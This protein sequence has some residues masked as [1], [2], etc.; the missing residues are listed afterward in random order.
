MAAGFNPQMLLQMLSRGRGGA[1]GGEES[2][3]PASREL[4]GA[5]PEYALKLVNDLKKKAADLIPMLAFR[6]PAAARA[7]ASTFKGL[8]A[9]IKELQQAQATL[10]AVGGPINMAAVPKPQPPGSTGAPGLSMAA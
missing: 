6:A 8:D 3:A 7:L 2:A 10:Q 5:D 4:Q 9:A 1:G